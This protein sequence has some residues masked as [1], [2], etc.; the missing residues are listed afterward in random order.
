M[1]Q[2]CLNLKPM[3]VM[4]PGVVDVDVRTAVPLRGIN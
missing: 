3:E 1:S 2:G 4:L